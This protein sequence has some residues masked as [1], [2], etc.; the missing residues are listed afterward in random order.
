MTVSGHPG[1]PKRG[2]HITI[3][4]PNGPHDFEMEFLHL[5]WPCGPHEPGWLWLHGIVGKED[6]AHLTYDRTQTLYARPT[7][8]P[9]VYETIPKR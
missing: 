1:I 7:D 6:W 4:W 2:Q 8:E 3:R 5:E 9:G